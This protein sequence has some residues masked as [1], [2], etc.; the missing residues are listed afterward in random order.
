M[1]QE[2]KQLLLQDLSGRLLYKVKVTTTNAAV[3]F[4]VI[5][6][7][8]IENK[9][10]V[11]T[12]RADIVFNCTEVKPYLFP[13]SS[14]TEEQKEEYESECNKD[15]KALSKAIRNRTYTAIR[16][17]TPLYYG[18]DWL[19]AHHFDYRG[20]IEKGLAK[21]ATDLNIY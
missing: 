20:L 12:K 5:S 15:L 16:I 17:S 3:E 11:G 1:T 18:I 6:G 10:S 8:S 9:I 19:N 4:G 21:D 13:L 2:E 14:M 7:I